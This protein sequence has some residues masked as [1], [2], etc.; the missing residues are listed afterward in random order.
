M[1]VQMRS[2]GTDGE[3]QRG[4]MV[5]SKGTDGEVLVFFSHYRSWPKEPCQ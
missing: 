1:A 3:V 5:R 2:K 4:Q